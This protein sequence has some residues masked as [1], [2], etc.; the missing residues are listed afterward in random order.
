MGDRIFLA[1]KVLIA[2][3]ILSASL[4]AEVQ[5]K[6]IEAEV[7]VYGATPAGVCAAV[8]AAREGVSVVLVCPMTMWG[9]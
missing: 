6:A 1:M 5:Q 8:G 9:E 4:H 7:I 2:A 3:L